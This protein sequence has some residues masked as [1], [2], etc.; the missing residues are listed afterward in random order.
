MNLYKV[1]PAMSTSM[2]NP[3]ASWKLENFFVVAPDIATAHLL[4]MTRGIREM[5]TVNEKIDKRNEEQRKKK[6]EGDDGPQMPG[7]MVMMMGGFPDGETPHVSEFK[8]RAIE[9]VMED[10]PVEGL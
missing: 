3:H 5:N 6:A 10:V 9:V 8:I 4:G 1:K 7:F 2:E